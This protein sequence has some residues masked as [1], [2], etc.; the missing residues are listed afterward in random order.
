MEPVTDGK[1]V[2][3][4]EGKNIMV[5]GLART[6][7]A[8]ARFVTRRGATVVGVDARA[9]GQMEQARAELAPLPAVCHFGAENPAWL[10]GVDAVVPSPGVPRDNPLLVEAARRG[11]EVLSEIELAARFASMPLAAVTGTNGKT[12]TTSLLA[13]MLEAAGLRVFAGGNIGKPFIDH[14]DE[15][16]DWGVVEV[17]SFQLEWVRE[18]RPRVALFLNLSEDHLD[19][20]DGL[21]SYGAAKARIFA[22]QQPGDVAVLNPPPPRGWG[23]RRP[24]GARGVYIG[25]AEVKQGA[26]VA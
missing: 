18:F 3:E 1:P 15:D 9:A 8:V 14:V 10:D 13:A 19:R 16:W 25:G 24:G 20:Y 23:R 6:G 5:L 2:M 7:L 17:S 4:L 22:A 12:T 11:M 26:V 21:E